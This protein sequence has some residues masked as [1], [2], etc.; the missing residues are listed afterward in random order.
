MLLRRGSV[1]G[2]RAAAGACSP[3]ENLSRCFGRPLSG[4]VPPVPLGRPRR[5]IGQSA[6]TGTRAWQANALPARLRLPCGSP[7]AVLCRCRA[8]G[9]GRN[10][11]SCCLPRAGARCVGTRRR[12][13]SQACSHSCA[14]SRPVKGD[15]RRDRHRRQRRHQDLRGGRH[16][17]R[18]AGRGRHPPRGGGGDR[19][20]PRRRRRCGPPGS[21]PAGCSPWWST[22]PTGA[23]PGGPGQASNRPT[24]GRSS[25]RRLGPVSAS[26][27]GWRAALG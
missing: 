1:L 11:C 15:Q 13:T 25:H 19:A 2:R 20:H 23:A 16:P 18:A 22:P 24:S 7:P 12:G 4:R 27:W 26:A 8:G 14:G 9:C 6:V 3:A 5:R 17:G 10:G 21:W